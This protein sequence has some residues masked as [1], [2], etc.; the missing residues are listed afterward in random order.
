MARPTW[1]NRTVIGAGLAGRIEAVESLARPSL[2]LIP[3]PSSRTPHRATRRPLLPLEPAQV[4]KMG[5]GPARSYIRN[6]PRFKKGL[7]KL[8]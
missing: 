4:E 1:L 5:G 2:R 8:G 7:K 6:G 3:G